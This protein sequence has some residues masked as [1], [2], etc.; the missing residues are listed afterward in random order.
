LDQRAV[1]AVVP[2][3][4]AGFAEGIIYA[5]F[6]VRIAN[7][8]VFTNF[9]ARTAMCAQGF[10]KANTGGVRQAFGIRAPPARQR[11]ALKKDHRSNPRSIVNGKTLDIRDNRILRID[12]FGLISR[13]HK[14]A[15][16][17]ITQGPASM[18][19]S[20]LKDTMAGFNLT[21]RKNQGNRLTSDWKPELNNHCTNHRMRYAHI[22]KL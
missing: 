18:N 14:G 22:R 19:K 9:F 3:G 6:A 21:S 2:T 10:D 17:H 12:L 5:V 20:P 8:A 1:V 7:G 4:A 13:F 15:H 11:A 16:P